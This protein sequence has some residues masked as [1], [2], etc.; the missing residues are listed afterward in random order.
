MAK[1]PV[2][3]KA[4]IGKQKV[5]VPKDILNIILGE[6]MSKA[7]RFII[8]YNMVEAGGEAAGKME[9]LSTSYEDALKFAVEKKFDVDGVKDFEANFKAAQSAA[10][11]GKTKRK[12]MPVIDDADVKKLQARLQKGTLDITKPFHK[13]T[14]PKD[15]FPTGLQGLDA[16]EFMKRGLKDGSKTD[17]IVPVSIKKKKISDLIPIQKQIFYDKSMEATAKFGIKGTTD[18]VSNKSFFVTSDDNFIIDGHHRFLSAMLLDPNMK[19]NALSID[20]PIK[21][22]LPLAVAYGDALGNKRNA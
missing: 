5:K 14:D 19:I 10:K 7:R 3:T 13:D 9:L 15:P 1:F 4:E 18:F 22:L 17:D 20:L 6:N 21:K 8:E 11:R 16:Q 2:Q 12:D